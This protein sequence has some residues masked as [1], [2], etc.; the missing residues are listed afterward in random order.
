VARS[1]QKLGENRSVKQAGAGDLARQ[2]NTAVAGG[3]QKLGE[4]HSAK[5]ADAGDRARKRATAD[6]GDL[7]KLGETRSTKK[8]DAGDRAEQRDTAAERLQK[9]KD[10]SSIKRIDEGA[11]VQQRNLAEFGDLQELAKIHST[12]PADGKDRAQQTDGLANVESSERGAKV[13]AALDVG[14]PREASSE[15]VV[16]PKGRGLRDDAYGEKIRKGSSGDTDNNARRTS[17]WK[18]DAPEFI[19]ASHW[20]TQRSIFNQGASKD[21]IDKENLW[22]MASGLLESNEALRAAIYGHVQQKH[23]SSETNESRQL[24]TALEPTMNGVILMSPK[25]PRKKKG[26][27]KKHTLRRHHTKSEPAGMGLTPFE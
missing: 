25:K 12:S 21:G 16:V 2:R 4:N 1:L 13:P 22:G 17:I 19:P 20:A 23:D 18:P 8:T 24:D 7:Q 6:A 26:S 11:E 3:L 15:T 5:Q 27:K 9:L 10:T 14:R